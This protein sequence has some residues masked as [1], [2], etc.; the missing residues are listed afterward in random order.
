MLELKIHTD[1]SAIGPDTWNRLC[2]SDYPFLRYEF[3]AALEHSNSVSPQ[4]GWQ[5]LHIAVEQNGETIAVM[6]L[7]LKTHSY[8]EYV[9]DWS[10]A[11]AYQRHGLDYYPKLVTA[12]PF[13]PAAGPRIGS[14]QPTETLMPALLDAIRQLAERFGAS[15]WHGLFVEPALRQCLEASGL[16]LRLGTQYHWFNA[17]FRSFD[18]FMEK[19]ASRKR[20]NIRRERQK[21]LDQQISLRRIEGTDLSPE[22]LDV[23]YAFYQNTYLKR[24][25]T[26]YLTPEF[27]QLLHRNMPEQLLLV[28]AEKDGQPVAGAL[29]LKSSSTLYGRY[30]GCLDDYDSLHFETCYYQGIEYCIGQGLARFDPGAQG[31]HK[32]QR[33]FQP[34][35]TWS[36]HWVKHPGFADAINKA[37]GTERDAMRAQIQELT[38]WLPFRKD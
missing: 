25:R 7:Y 20:K 35:E 3:L 28:L 24:G 4:T 2:G 15:S 8:G 14:S 36:G 33:G 30:W 1:I 23:F 16:T 32:I 34:I 13:T 26:G 31:E 21:V 29:S 6:P 12:I 10:W 18:H 17:D 11:D 27:F 22:L 9:F 19:F 38:T 37:M 5:P